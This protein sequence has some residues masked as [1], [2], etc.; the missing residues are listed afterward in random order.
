ML[1]FYIFC[2]ILGGGLVTFSLFAGT[3]GGTDAD[4]EFD[5]SHQ[6][7]AEHSTDL[8]SSNSISHINS[9]NTKLSTAHSAEMVKFFSIRN[10]TYFA[11]FFGLTGTILTLLA[12][13]ATWTLFASLFAGGFSA[14]FS[15][16]LMKYLKKSES[17]QSISLYNLIGSK[18][19]VTI[20]IKKNSIGKINVIVQGQIIEIPAKLS[21]T[22]ESEEIKP[23]EEI[24]IIDFT[25]IAIVSKYDL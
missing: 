20:P 19:T 3:D 12:S 24:L 1:E 9:A 11:A 5:A 14:F 15:Y 8:N 25:D 4:S 13:S 17:G 18:G 10:L 22:S 21:E 7:D 2:L 23:K 6:L 16:R